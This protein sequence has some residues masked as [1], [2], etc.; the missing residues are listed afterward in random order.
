[1]KDEAEEGLI[2]KPVG[3]A[4]RST[5]YLGFRIENAENKLY[6]KGY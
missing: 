6:H 5:D 4:K 1:M 2:G 3:S